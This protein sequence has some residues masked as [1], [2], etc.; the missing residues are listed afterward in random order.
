M[1]T[2]KKLEIR[3]KR[4]RV[5]EPNGPYGKYFHGPQD[6]RK[7]AQQLLE[8]EEQEVFLVFILNIRNQ[9][10]G[11]V[12]VGR[13][14]IDSCPVDPRTVFRAA[15]LQGASG[16]VVSHNHPSG[17]A[18]PSTE[19]DSITKKLVECGKLLGIPVLDHV[20]V[21]EDTYFSYAEEGKL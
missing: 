18:G 21:T 16:I 1:K 3:S 10:V 20:I 9:I 6:V 7:V 4:I 5:A 19:D 15:V 8:G 17:F 11:Y 14:A 13:G 2:V 12:E